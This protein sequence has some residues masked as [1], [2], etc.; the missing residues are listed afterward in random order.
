MKAGELRTKSVNELQEELAT[1]QRELFNLKLKG[2]VKG[3]GQVVR[4][5]VFSMARKK[6]ARIETILN[7]KRGI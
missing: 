1:S 5:H 4:T 3:D 6:I 7:E 2:N